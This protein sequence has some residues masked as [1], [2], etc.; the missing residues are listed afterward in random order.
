MIEGTDKLNINSRS[1]VSNVSVNVK[2]IMYISSMLSLSLFSIAG[3]IIGDV[4]NSVLGVG[5]GM[6][7]KSIGYICYGFGVF[8]GSLLWFL[9]YNSRNE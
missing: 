4:E 1:N 7:F 9:G 5:L 3:L 6:L 2:N 8:C